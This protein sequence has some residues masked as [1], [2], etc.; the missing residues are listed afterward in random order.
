[1]YVE[2]EPTS[3]VRNAEVTEM[4]NYA[5]SHYQAKV[6]YAKGQTIA[7][8]PVA[9]GQELSVPVAVRQTAYLLASKVDNHVYGQAVLQ[10]KPLKAPV[11]SGQQA[12]VVK[13]LFD[14]AVV[15]EYPVVTTAAVQ[16]VTLLEMLGRAMR[17]TLLLG[18]DR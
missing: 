4:M 16:R 17:R 18:A 14:G 2:G 5:F 3:K 8:A 11:R 10:M 9:H 7:Q 12:G 15:A 1:M 6:V 13:I